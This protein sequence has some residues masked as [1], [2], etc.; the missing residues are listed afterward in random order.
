MP[1]KPS[2]YDD[3]YYSY[4]AWRD[5]LGHLYNDFFF[6]LLLILTQTFRIIELVFTI[7]LKSWVKYRENFFDQTNEPIMEYD[8]GRLKSYLERD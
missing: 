5:G 7:F 2:I 4:K 6:I 1:V 3:N 8:N